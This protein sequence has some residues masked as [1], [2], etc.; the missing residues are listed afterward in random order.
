MRT[1][2]FQDADNKWYYF[3]NDGSMAMETTT[4]DGFQVNG[5]GV[6]IR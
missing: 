1:G 2:W 4:P 3:Q 6:W 5:E